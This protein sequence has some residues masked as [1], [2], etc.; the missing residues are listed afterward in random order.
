VRYVALATDYDGTIALHGRVDE[1]TLSALQRVR[2]SGRRLILVTG[3]ELDDLVGVFPNVDLFDRIVAENGALLYDPAA[4][5]K[6]PLG[7]P[8]ALEFVQELTRRGVSPLSV[9][10]VIV[11]T[12]EPNETTVFEVIRDLALELQVVFNKGAVMVLPTGTNKAT[13]LRAALDELGLSVRNTVG[14]GDA[15]NDQ[16][17]LAACECG[18]AVA[19]AL[20]SVKAR[21]D[22]VT[23]GD[24]GTGVAELVDRL[25]LSDLEDLAPRLARHELLIGHTE[26]GDEVHVP[27]FG[28]CIL[29]AGPSGA[30]KTTVTTAFLERIAAAGYQYCIVDPEGDYLDLPG[31]VALASSE[32]RSLVNEVL[33][34]LARPSQ[35]V[36]VSLLEVRL[37][38]RPP[39]FGTLLPR[40]QELRAG[41]GRPHWIVVDEAHHLMPTN[42]EPTRTTLPGELVNLMLVTVHPD[43]VALPV[44]ELV[45][46]LIVVGRDA[47]ATAAAFARSRPASTWELPDIVEDVPP[48]QA[49]LLSVRHSPMRFTIVPPESERRRHRRK[50]AEGEL[51]A[52]KS[53]YFRGP[54]GRLNLRAQNLQLFAQIAE[55][56]DDETWVHHLRNQDY[57]RWFRESIKDDAL[58]DQVAT[59]EQSEGLSPMESRARV[60]AAIEERYTVPP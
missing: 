32:P 53:F 40:L 7:D 4:R 45:D 43:H 56:V 24:H 28:A 14:I 1:A 59:I 10:E 21:V 16:A 46:T 35:N 6:R 44:L 41:T 52:N 13:G 18:V 22:F 19:N 38:D 39:T 49:W 9:G 8:P 3:R 29:V 58:A 47:T 36:A 27:P 60:R 31:A 5:T 50:Y 17:F 48:G 26:T 23:D 54:H 55:G 2:A 12:W 33:Q 11:A 30:G 25:L 51:G 37:D 20:D 15:E 57:S 34:V 42:W